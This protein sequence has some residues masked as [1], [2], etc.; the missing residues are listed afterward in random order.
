VAQDGITDDTETLAGAANL[1][2]TWSA[3]DS[4][5]VVDDVEA[6]SR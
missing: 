5:S 3:P 4:C 6:A 2:M 1:D